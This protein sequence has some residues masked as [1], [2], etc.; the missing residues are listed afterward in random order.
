MQW[1]SNT[2]NLSQ[3]ERS[4]KY[5]S[6]VMNKAWSKFWSKINWMPCSGSHACEKQ[7]CCCLIQKDSLVCALSEEYL[8]TIL[9]SSLTKCV[10]QILQ[11][12]QTKGKLK[13]CLK[14]ITTLRSLNGG[15]KMSVGAFV[16][17]LQLLVY[18]REKYNNYLSLF[19]AFEYKLRGV[20]WG[21][22]INWICNL[23]VLF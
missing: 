9:L 6:E 5:T 23:V 14:K 16:F 11:E 10:Q 21:D 17:M 18:V 4:N 12:R 22:C 7:L 1:P 15:P 3:S 19:S 8:T 13:N 2:V 20:T